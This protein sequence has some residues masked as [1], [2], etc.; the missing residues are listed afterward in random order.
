M[1]GRRAKERTRNFGLL[2][3]GRSLCFGWNRAQM[4]LEK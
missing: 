3:A 4:V 2:G 1:M